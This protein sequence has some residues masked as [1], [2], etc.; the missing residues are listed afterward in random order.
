MSQSKVVGRRFISLKI[1]CGLNTIVSL[2]I[3]VLVNKHST[4]HTIVTR[5]VYTI[6]DALKQELINE[7]LLSYSQ[8]YNSS[9]YECKRKSNDGQLERKLNATARLLPTLGRNIAP[10]PNDYFHGRGIVLTV[11]KYQLPF[12]KVNLEMI[13]HTRTRLPVQVSRSNH[14]YNL[15]KSLSLF[16]F[17]IHQKKFK[18]KMWLTY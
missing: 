17:G 1:I 12:A 9:S 11:G 10:Y 14:C 15:S 7:H 13:Q 3:I 18:M 2:F 4:Y 5:P 16:R 6:N 8:F